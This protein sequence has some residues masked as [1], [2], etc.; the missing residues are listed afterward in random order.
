MA[1]EIYKGYQ[2]RGIVNSFFKSLSIGTSVSSTMTEVTGMNLDITVFV[3]DL[4][5]VTTNVNYI[6]PTA[7]VAVLAVN[8][9]V[10]SNGT[11]SAVNKYVLGLPNNASTG[12]PLTWSTAY[13]V[14]NNGTLT[15]KTMAASN[16]GGS[17]I[18][19][20]GVNAS[21]TLPSNIIVHQYRTT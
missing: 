8:K 15:V 10:E 4:L 3:G 19:I 1:N 7:S 5:Y 17:N 9:F 6:S 12:A 21:S 14:L 2:N 18:T 20:A 16:T 13:T 11:E